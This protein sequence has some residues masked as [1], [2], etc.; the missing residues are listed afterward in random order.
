M[1][2]SRPTRTIS[3]LL[4]DP[5]CCAAA[6]LRSACCCALP[7]AVLCSACCCVLPF[8]SAYDPRAHFSACSQRVYSHRSLSDRGWL[9][10][11]GE[12][13]VQQGRAAGFGG[14]T[15][16]RVHTSRPDLGN[17]AEIMQRCAD[18]AMVVSS[19]HP[20]H[21]RTCCSQ[22]RRG[23]VGGGILTKSPIRIYI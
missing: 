8:C 6:V 22:P 17:L 2:L 23:G 1:M 20:S 16:G 4:Y 9:T 19:V 21:F 3:P 13:C 12:V 10:A 5:L 7:A 11:G 14:E 18:V 15:E